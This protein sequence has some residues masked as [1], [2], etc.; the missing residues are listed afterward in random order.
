[1][2]AV[3]HPETDE[4]LEAAALWYEERHSGLGNELL[5][6]FEDTLHRIVADP[7]RWSKV[8]AG[9]CKLNSPRFP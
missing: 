6:P 8:R 7:K 3:S 5:D 4:E 9:N 1:M 2:R